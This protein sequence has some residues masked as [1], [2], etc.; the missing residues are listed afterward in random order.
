[1]TPIARRVDGELTPDGDPLLAE[2]AERR[3]SFLAKMDDDFNTGG[4][5]SDLFE[6]VRLLN[7]FSDQQRLEETAARD[8]KLLTA[9]RRGVATLRELTAIFGLFRRPP[10]K[11]AAASDALVGKLMELLISLRAEARTKK[12]FAT[13]DK[14]RDSLTALGVVL[15]DRKDGTL[16][17]AS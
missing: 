6:L 1:M 16:W 3:A 5:S 9:F 13:S 8:E 10:Q 14:I 15:E 12:D 7:K 11:Q 17:R 4:A 2:V